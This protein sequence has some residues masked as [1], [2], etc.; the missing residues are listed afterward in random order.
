MEEMFAME[1]ERAPTRY[2]DA[3]V[4]RSGVRDASA[5]QRDGDRGVQ[6]A[7]LGT[8]LGLGLGLADLR[9]RG[10]FSSRGNL[11]SPARSA[12]STRMPL[13]CSA[14]PAVPRISSDV[15]GIVSRPRGVVALP[16]WVG[17]D[18]SFT[19]TLAASV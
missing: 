9:T 2:K 5:V 18:W 8:W 1:L 3:F 4:L 15:L 13:T 6:P 12:P 16:A 17:E 7:A 10:N 19:L 14:T 11:S